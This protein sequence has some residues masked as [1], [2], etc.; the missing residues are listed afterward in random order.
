MP[1]L[2]ET[3]SWGWTPRLPESVSGLQATLSAI[4]GSGLGRRQAWVLWPVSALLHPGGAN[5]NRESL[6]LDHSVQGSKHALVPKLK[7]NGME[8]IPKEGKGLSEESVQPVGRG[9]ERPWCPLG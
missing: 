7:G 3:W 9:E 8:R 4:P 2:R 5:S 1:S 6:L